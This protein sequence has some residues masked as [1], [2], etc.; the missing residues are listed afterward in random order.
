MPDS[1]KNS[2]L[3]TAI[4][5]LANDFPA[6][7]FSYDDPGKRMLKIRKNNATSIFRAG[8]SFENSFLRKLQKKNT[9]NA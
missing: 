4:A 9:R 8:I 6:G 2:P 1:Y 7:G 5:A 3:P